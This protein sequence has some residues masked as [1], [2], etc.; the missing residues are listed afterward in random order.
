MS[1]LI[2]LGIDPG[3]AHLGLATVLRD[4]ASYH[5][6]VM[7]SHHTVTS[8]GDATDRVAIMRD[9]VR[10]FLESHSLV[11]VVGIEDVEVRRHR[12]EKIDPSG[13]LHVARV[14]GGIEEVCSRKHVYVMR[15]SEW[16]RAIG[17]GHG[18]NAEVRAAVERV[19]GPLDRRTSVHARDAVGIA[20]AALARAR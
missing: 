13:I 18:T 20:L 16:R 8:D 4:G 17:A 5:V 1:A 15:A 9:A 19:V 14:L 3:F 10:I 11:R 7:T 12:G 6:G 2:A